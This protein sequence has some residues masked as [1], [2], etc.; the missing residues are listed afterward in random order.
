MLDHMKKKSGKRSVSRSTSLHTPGWGFLLCIQ[1]TYLCPA[2]SIL[3]SDP[4]DFSLTRIK[5][6]FYIHSLAAVLV[7]EKKLK[8][9]TRLLLFV[10]LDFNLGERETSARAPFLLFL[11]SAREIKQCV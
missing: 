5:L 8:I 2:T 4:N 10:F 6:H 9:H 11:F 3:L 7:L 1:I